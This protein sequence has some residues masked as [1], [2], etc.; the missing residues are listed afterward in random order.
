VATFQKKEHPTPEWI[1]ANKT[2]W[3][4]RSRFLV[5]TWTNPL[6]PSQGIGTQHTVDE[7]TWRRLTANR[8]VAMRFFC[9]MGE[10]FSLANLYENAIEISGHRLIRTN[11]R[12]RG[13]QGKTVI[14]YCPC[15]QIAISRDDRIVGLAD[16]AS[17]CELTP[18][19]YLK[20]R[21]RTRRVEDS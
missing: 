8:I 11:F 4:P 18:C 16:D 6:R 7:M 14:Y 13:P 17:E 3:G 1:A 12:V 9:T 20:P 21:P 5:K 15:G 19:T 10:R 2:R